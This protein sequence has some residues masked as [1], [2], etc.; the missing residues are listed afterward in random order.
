MVIFFIDSRAASLHAGDAMKIDA[1]LKKIQSLD[2]LTNRAGASPDETCDAEYALYV[3][4]SDLGR[5]V[6]VPS[7]CAPLAY[8]EALSLAWGMTPERMKGFKVM[9]FSGM[10]GASEAILHPTLAKIRLANDGEFG[11]SVEVIK[12]L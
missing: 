9:R 2:T 6:Q 10:G 4:T 12:T 7:D 3:A 1:L 5:K 8:G 11:I